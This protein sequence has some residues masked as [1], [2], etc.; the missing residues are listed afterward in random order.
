MNS[1]RIFKKLNSSKFFRL[2]LLTVCYYNLNTT[3]VC[4]QVALNVS[5]SDLQSYLNLPFSLQSLNI[6]SGIDYLSV[7]NNSSAVQRVYLKANAYKDNIEIF[8]ARSITLKLNPGETKGFNKVNYQQLYN[9]TGSQIEYYD[10]QVKNAVLSTSYLPNGIYYFCVYLYLESNVLLQTECSTKSKVE[11]NQT[12]IQNTHPFDGDTINETLPQFIWTPLASGKAGVEYDL[13]LYELLDAKPN[14]ATIKS[15]P[16][17]FKIEGIK[18][19]TLQYS[20]KNRSLLENQSYVWYVIAKNSLGKNIAQSEPTTFTFKD[21]STQNTTTVSSIK[22]NG[23]YFNIDFDNIYSLNR[24]DSIPLLFR[25]RS[26]ENFLVYKIKNS[27]GEIINKGI[28]PVSDGVN[29]LKVPLNTSLEKIK[30]ICVV[31]LFNEQGKVGQLKFQNR[32]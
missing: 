28:L 13:F 19:F 12:G 2:I 5:Y 11:V 14:Y 1:L 7:T 18:N 6:I 26:K 17:W 22:S 23:I 8:R 30:G 29:C 3:E 4:A 15:V 10:S 25:N 21:I 16:E 9:Q 31:E 27:M 32:K 20:S 24:T